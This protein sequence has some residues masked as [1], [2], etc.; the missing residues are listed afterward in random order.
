MRNQIPVRTVK[1][2]LNSYGQ[3]LEGGSLEEMAAEGEYSAGPSHD[4]I[5]RPLTVAILAMISLTNAIDPLDGSLTNF[6][7]I[8]NPKVTAETKGNEN[9]H[10]NCAIQ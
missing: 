2:L 1:K 8:C 3:E 10:S 9:K 6:G 7:W 5:V 4:G